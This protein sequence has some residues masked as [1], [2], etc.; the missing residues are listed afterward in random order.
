MSVG[1]WV[2]G[3]VRSSEV[4]E[5]PSLLVYDREDTDCTSIIGAWS[6][7]KHSGE[8]IS[9]TAHL[10]PTL[11]HAWVVPFSGESCYFSSATLD[12]VRAARVLYQKETDFCTGILFE[13][14]NGG[15]RA[16]G[17]CAAPSNDFKAYTDPSFICFLATT[18]TRGYDVTTY[19]SRVSFSSK[20]CQSDDVQCCRRMSGVLHFW[21]SHE[22]TYLQVI[23]G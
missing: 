20:S 5:Q 2:H 8:P 23:E 21:F 14:K 3:D 4:I 9:R 19:Q 7:T 17:R 18:S 11:Q 16:V 1:S 15:K 22:S 13:Y 12:S 10:L 6:P